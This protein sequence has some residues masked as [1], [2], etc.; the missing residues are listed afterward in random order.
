MRAP[1]LVAVV[2]LAAVLP[3]DA[4]ARDWAATLLPGLLLAAPFAVVTSRASLG[5]A[6]RRAGLLLTPEETAPSP[7]LR[8]YQR[9]MAWPRPVGEH[10]HPAGPAR[11]QQAILALRPTPQVAEND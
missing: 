8:A 9:A 1:A 5:I 6:A 4:S 10:A 2:W 7:I 11:L 3:L